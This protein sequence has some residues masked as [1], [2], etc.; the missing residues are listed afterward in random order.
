MHR[1]MFFSCVDMDV[2]SSNQTPKFLVQA[3]DRMSLSPTRKQLLRSNLLSWYWVPMSNTSVLS[4]FS[5]SRVCVNELQSIDIYFHYNLFLWS[6]EYM[7][8]HGELRLKNYMKVDHRNYRCNFCSGEKKAVKK[9]RLS[10]RNCKSCVY[11]C[12]DYLFL[13]IQVFLYHISPPMTF[14]F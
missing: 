10:F 1:C 4:S 7:K 6:Y 2:I 14:Y 11:N 5:L 3:T 8:N 9:F 13:I 12:N